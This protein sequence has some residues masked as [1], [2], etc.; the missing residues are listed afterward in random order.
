MKNKALESRRTGP[1]SDRDAAAG[2][3]R[4]VNEIC[5]VIVSLDV[6]AR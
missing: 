2:G 4:A 5:G 1:S 3:V 6:A